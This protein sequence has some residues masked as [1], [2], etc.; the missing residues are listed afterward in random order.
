MKFKALFLLFILTSLTFAQQQRRIVQPVNDGNM[1]RLAGTVH[2]RLASA[3]DQGAVSP[4]MQLHGMRL[5]FSRSPQQQTALDQ[6]LAEQQDPNSANYH[7]W[8]TPEEFGAQFGLA[9]ADIVTLSAWLTAQGFT[10]D[11]VARGR[12]FIVFSGIAAQVEAAFHAPIHNYLVGGK[13]HFAASTDVSIP[14]AFSGVVS[15]V[16]G[17]HNFAPKA[18][19][20]KAQPRVTSSIT[21]NHFIVPGDFATIYN[22]P[23]YSAGVP[24][25]GA[26]P[27][28]LNGTGQTI[29]IVGQSN[30]STDSN[31]GRNGTPGVNGQQYDLVTF[32]NLAGL[33]ALGTAPTF[34]IVIVPPYGDPGVAADAAE[35]NLDVEWSGAAAPNANLIFVVENSNNGGDGAFGALVYAVDNNLAP[36]ISVSYGVCEAQL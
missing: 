1:V 5:V 31:P 12:D 20:I 23:S 25:T 30:L 16:T 36:V 15:G 3:T 34:Q 17:L 2:P 26:P 11:S 7:K 8:L 6:L 33:P 21:G 35:A 28:C 29:A 24:C 14:G 9:Q 27:A 13:A 4:T 10:V 19:N 18:R 32:R 22:L